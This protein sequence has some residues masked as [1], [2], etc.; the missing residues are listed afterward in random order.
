MLWTGCFFIGRRYRD[1]KLAEEMQRY[2]TL[3]THKSSGLGSK[4]TVLASVVV[5]KFHGSSASLLSSDNSPASLRKKQEVIQMA[6]IGPSKASRLALPLPLP[7]QFDKA[8]VAKYGKS[9]M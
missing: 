6:E 9:S 1:S 7:S 4:A 2:Q 8:I 5:E 3:T